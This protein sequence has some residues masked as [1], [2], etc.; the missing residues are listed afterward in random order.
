MK[1]P[2][3]ITDQ[4]QYRFGN[5]HLHKLPKYAKVKDNNIIIPFKKGDYCRYAQPSFE[6]VDFIIEKITVEYGYF[7]ATDSF[8]REFILDFCFKLKK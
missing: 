8:N 2:F 7:T 5:K 3:V 1:F 6:C 4:N